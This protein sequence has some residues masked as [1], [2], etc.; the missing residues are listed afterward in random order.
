M[1]SG[2]VVTKLPV[3]DLPIRAQIARIGRKDKQC[4]DQTQTKK[5]YSLISIDLGFLTFWGI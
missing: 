3:R 2:R 5:C 4:I 1:P